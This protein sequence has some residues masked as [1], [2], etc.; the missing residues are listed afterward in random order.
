MTWRLDDRLRDDVKHEAA[1]TGRSMNEY[2]TFIARS[3]TDETF[4]GDEGDRIRVRLRRAGLSAE[5]S[6]PI[7]NRPDP[8]AVAAAR[9]AA[10]RGTSL[11][12]LVSEG[13]G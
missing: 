10:G 6:G 2:V 8:E 7:V 9:R 13:R 5:P 3:A 11:A 12:D 1:R 4:G